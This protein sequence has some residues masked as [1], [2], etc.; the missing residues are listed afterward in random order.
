MK[1]KK[2]SITL[3]RASLRCNKAKG[4]VDESESHDGLFPYFDN[5]PS[6]ITTQILLQLSIKS[7]LICKCVCKIWKTMISEP[8]FAKLQFERA[9]LSLMIRTNDGRLVSRTMYLLECDHEK[10]EIGS[11][12]H[13]K[14][15]PIFKLPLRNANSYREKI[16]NKPKRPIRA[17]RLALEKNGENSN[18]DSQRLNIDFKPYYDKFGV[19]N[20]C[21]GL[22]CLCCPS[23]EHPLSICNPVTGEFI[24][25]PEATINTH[26][27]RSPLNMRGQVGFG[28]QPKT[29]EYKVIRI[30]GSDVKRGNRWV[31]DRMVLEIYTLGTPSWRNA[32]VDPQISIGSNIWL[33]YP[34]CVNGTI[35]WIRFKG[36][37]RSILCFCL[38]NERLQSFPSPP[39]LQN[40]N[41]GFRHNECIRIGE[42]RGLLYIC[43][44][45]FFRDVAMWVM[46]EY[47]IGES[48]TK[49]YNID[50]LV[51]PLGRP[52]SQRY[53]I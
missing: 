27:E 12:N 11:N 24:K 5:L 16:E 10:F 17:A 6:H 20:S 47:G 34:T 30:W 33:R 25:L 3:A 2:G 37:E 15:A 40:Q 8:H 53:G 39:V 9:P 49:V 28:F 26:D 43:D 31:F 36:Q 7:L 38:E 50:T 29:N 44:T 46:N 32:E 22:L 19:A 1:R 14:L 52:D 23:D 51:S 4:R 45:S 48:W 41:N 18:G 35:H 13:V 21:N 42:L